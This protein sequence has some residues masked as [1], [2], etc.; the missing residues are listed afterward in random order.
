MPVQHF[1]V[2]AMRLVIT[3]CWGEVLCD[4]VVHGLEELRLNPDFNPDF[5]QLTDLS[6]VSKLHLGFNDMDVIHCLH[7]P[8]SNVG[9]RA[10][11][12]PGHNALYGLARMYQLLVDHEHFEVFHHLPDA[13]AWVGLEITAVE[14][15]MRK[16]VPPAPAGKTSR[17]EQLGKVGTDR[18]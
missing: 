8:F 18:T 14:A 4:E 9:K 16:A 17:V 7:D 3:L 6:Q 11:I 12:A 2:P 1:V 5:A 15:A 10:V 13:V